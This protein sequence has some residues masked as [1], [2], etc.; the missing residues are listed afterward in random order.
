[1]HTVD[2]WPATFMAIQKIWDITSNFSLLCR[3]SYSLSFSSCDGNTEILGWPSLASA[4]N[5]T[6]T[7]YMYQHT[8]RP[9]KYK[10]WYFQ[11]CFGTTAS[12][13]SCK[14]QVENQWKLKLKN[15]T[16]NN[17]QSYKSFLKPQER[18]WF[19]WIFCFGNSFLLSILCSLI[20]ISLHGMN[21]WL[22][23]EISFT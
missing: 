2:V 20:V 17:A 6:G 8:T 22:C 5:L 10:L 1:M 3:G 13:L 15:K 23:L 19:K 11:W 18:I 4:G 7:S 21:P 16:K 12:S 9:E 14:S